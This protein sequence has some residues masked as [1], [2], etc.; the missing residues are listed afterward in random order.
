M[1][2][3]LESRLAVAARGSTSITAW[4]EDKVVNATQDAILPVDPVSGTAGWL[5]LT[6]ALP[7]QNDTSGKAGP[8]RIPLVGQKNVLVFWGQRMRSFI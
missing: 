3:E 2:S 8:A 6:P 1:Q 5:R 4:E 7:N